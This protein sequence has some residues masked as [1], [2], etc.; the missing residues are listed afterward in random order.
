MD[1]SLFWKRSDHS[2]KDVI[3]DISLVKCTGSSANPK[4]IFNVSVWYLLLVDTIYAQEIV[5]IWS[6]RILC[7]EKQNQYLLI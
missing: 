7:H 1:L 4:N 5:S 3:Q 6:L 2:H